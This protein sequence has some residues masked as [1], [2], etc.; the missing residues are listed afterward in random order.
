[1]SETARVPS[2][3]ASQMIVRTRIRG[4]P[5]G[6]TSAPSSRRRSAQ[7]SAWR[8]SLPAIVRKAAARCG[9]RSIEA[10]AS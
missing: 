10:R 4:R 5:A 2:S 9:S 6:G 8:R 3:R 7:I 1:M